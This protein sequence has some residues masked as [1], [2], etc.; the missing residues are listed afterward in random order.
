[1]KI[2]KKHR[3]SNHRLVQRLAKVAPA[4]DAIFDVFN[5]LTTLQIF[6]KRFFFQFFL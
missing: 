5:V 3:K 2:T 6:K 1:M 4:Y